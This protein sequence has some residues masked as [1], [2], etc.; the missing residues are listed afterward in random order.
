MKRKAFLLGAVG[1][2][3][4]AAAAKL[5]PT[6]E[7]V[8]GPFYPSYEHKDKDFDL[9]RVSGRSGTAKGRV[10]EIR[11]AVVDTDGNAVEDATV[12]LWQA[13]AAGRYRH[14]HD[15][16]N[17]PLDPYFQGW[18]I[19]PSG[20]DGAFCFRTIYPGTYPASEGW[21]RP[22]HIHFKVSKRGF[23][24][25][26]TQMYFPGEVLNQVDHLLQRKSESE[27]A[28]MIATLVDKDPPTYGYQLVLERV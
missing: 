27:Q 5:A 22:P 13:N 2:A 16:S 3:G 28:A 20:K 26:I 12:D 17:A 24:E 6:P 7:E 8:E 18:A 9:T 4:T 15:P 21:T 1:A 14:P 25:L 11:G 23:V 10:I 19:V